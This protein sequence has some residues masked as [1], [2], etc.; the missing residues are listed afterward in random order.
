MGCQVCLHAVAHEASPMTS[1]LGF[2]GAQTPALLPLS[3]EDNTH[4]QLGCGENN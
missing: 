4:W 2:A 1:I 3:N